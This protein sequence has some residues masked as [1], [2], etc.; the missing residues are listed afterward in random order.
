MEDAGLVPCIQIVAP[1]GIGH[2]KPGGKGK[3]LDQ[4]SKGHGRH[5]RKGIDEEQPHCKQQQV[6]YDLQAVQQPPFEPHL[7]EEALGIP[8][9]PG[10]I[11]PCQPGRRMLIHALLNPPSESPCWP[12]A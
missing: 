2:P 5:P 6:V 9:F 8:D 11:R 12:A 7:K 3:R 1:L 4:G 10:R